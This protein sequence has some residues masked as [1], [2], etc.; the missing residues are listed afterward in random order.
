[1][2]RK[3]IIERRIT[4]KKLRI[5]IKSREKLIRKRER[6]LKY[7]KKEVRVLKRRYKKAR[8]EKRKTTTIPVKRIRKQVTIN[9][10]LETEPYYISIRA[11]TIN[12]EITDRGLFLTIIPYKNRIDEQYNIKGKG[13]IAYETKPIPQSEDKQLNDMK[14]HIEIFIKRKATY[15]IK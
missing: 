10:R 7:E 11:I 1:M 14:V 13:Y 6:E 12:P 4:L 9:Y 2:K 15:F 8:T 5:L 3:I